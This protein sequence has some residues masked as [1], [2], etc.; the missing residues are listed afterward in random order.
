MVFLASC[1]L[2]QRDKGIVS[3][4]VRADTSRMLQERLEESPRNLLD[5]SNLDAGNVALATPAAASNPRAE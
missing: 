4:D 5:H 3:V 1:V 2:S